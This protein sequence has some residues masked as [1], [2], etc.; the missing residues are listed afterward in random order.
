LAYSREKASEK[1]EIPHSGNEGQ[2]IAEDPKQL[3]SLHEKSPGEGITGRHLPP[4]TDKTDI[5]ESSPKK[6]KVADAERRPLLMEGKKTLFQRVLTRPGALLNR[7]SQNDGNTEDVWKK[8]DPFTIFCVFDR[9]SFMGR[10]WVEVGAS[11][12]GPTEGWIDERQLIDWKQTLTVAFTNP[13]GRKR[14]LLFRDKNY[15]IDLVDSCNA[16]ARSEALRQTIQQGAIPEDFPVI[17]IEPATHIDIQ[18]QFYLLPIL[19]ANEVF[20]ASG[21][22]VRA[23]KIASVTLDEGDQDLI[24]KEENRKSLV[25]E[26][27]KQAQVMTEF[28]AGVV[29]VIDSTTSMGPYID[30]TR[31]AVRQIYDKL[32][33]ADLLGQISF[34]LVAYRDNIDKVPKLG[35]V[36]HVYGNLRDG[37]RPSILLEKISAVQPASVSSQGFVEDAFAGILSAIEDMNWADYDGRYLILITDAGARRGNDPLSA[38]RMNAEQIRRLALDKGI[39]TYCLHIL[40][41]V[42]KK[43]HESAAIQY[44][45]LTEYPAAGSL[46]YPVEGGSVQEFGFVTDLLAGA[47]VDQVIDASKGYVAKDIANTHSDKKDSSPSDSGKDQQHPEDSGKISEIKAKT[48]LVG[49]A[50]Q[51]AYLGKEK[52]TQAPRLFEAWISDRDFLSPD[53]PTVDVHVLLTKNQLSDLQQTLKTIMRAGKASMESSKGFFDELRSAAAALSR[54]P[55]EIGK[56]KTSRLGEQGLLGEYLDGLPY[57]SKVMSISDDLW[58]SWSIGEQQDFLDEVEAK[59]RLYEEYHDDVDRWIALDAGRVPGDAVY[60]VPLDDLP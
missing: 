10:N 51:L 42:G 19:D 41:E 46:Y 57:Q 31:E 58:S 54:D 39:A 34:G 21:F 6:A 3:A 5:T 50:M 40:S 9:K 11:T 27:P 7:V 36:S 29:F 17:S 26:A 53:T 35:Y 43:N 47:F 45:S 23:L 8:V 12:S 38:T 32:K 28:R 44:Q 56:S 52:G 55:N 2:A 60:P 14:T 1:K 24:I 33:K 25:Q 20:L 4:T 30:R 13:A 16:V 48:L 18:K 59:I 15:L 37:E 49:R 22:N